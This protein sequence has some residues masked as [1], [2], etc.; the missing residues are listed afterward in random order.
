MV[1]RP[2]PSRL[3]AV[4]LWPLLLL[5]AVRVVAQPMALVVHS[6]VLPPFESWHSAT[7]PYSLL[8]ASQITILLVLGWTTWHFTIGDVK[9][10]RGAGTL[11]LALGG[12]YFATMAVRLVL[13]FTAL[14]HLRWFASPIPTVFHLVLATSLLL[15]GR[16]HYVYGAKMPRDR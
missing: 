8:L 3:Y 6:P 15:Y 14:S 12:L 10:R 7:L 5:F 13:G 16:F 4:G 9:P 2:I 11:A 1:T